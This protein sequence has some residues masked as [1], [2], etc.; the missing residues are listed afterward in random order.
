MLEL[1]SKR[2]FGES[3]TAEGIFELCNNGWREMA[4]LFLLL[5]GEPFLFEKGADEE[6]NLETRAA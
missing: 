2:A 3:C 5:L 6:V 1:L 4:V